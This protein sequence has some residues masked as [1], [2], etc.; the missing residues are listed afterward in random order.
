MLH[1]GVDF[2]AALPTR[3]GADRLR[4][5]VDLVE[6]QPP[7]LGDAQGIWL[8]S[9]PDLVAAAQAMP[10]WPTPGA[11]KSVNGV[12]IVKLGEPTPPQLARN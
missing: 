7:G 12:V 11:V 1:E 8:S 3:A 10:S 6:Q 5:E 4:G 9:R 2:E